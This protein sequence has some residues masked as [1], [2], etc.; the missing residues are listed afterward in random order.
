MMIKIGNFTIND[1]HV[2]YTQRDTV[3]VPETITLHLVNGDPLVFEGDQA[4][5]LA[6]HFEDQA[7]KVNI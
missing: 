2:V 6:Q 1:A 5:A 4:V 3:A 7:L